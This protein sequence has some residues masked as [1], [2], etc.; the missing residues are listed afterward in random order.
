MP[1]AR[2]SDLN[3][4]KEEVA[5]LIDKATTLSQ[6]YDDSIESDVERDHYRAPGIHASEISKCKRRMVY[7][8][9]DTPK[10]KVGIT[11]K[12][13][14]RFQMGK[15]IHLMIQNDFHR[16]AVRSNGLIQ[17]D[18]EVPI[19]PKFQAIA[20]ELNLH[21]S[22][23][24][25]FTFRDHLLG[26]ATLRVGVEIKTESPDQFEDLKAPR[27]EHIEQAH[28]YMKALDLPLF[29][30]MYFNKGNQNNTSSI[31]PYLI[32]FNQTLWAKLEARCR[33]VLKM[34]ADREVPDREE[35]IHCQ[36][37]PYSAVCQPPFLSK[38]SGGA[39]KWQQ[40]RRM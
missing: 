3:G 8:I 38:K 18:S 33:L 24:G 23:D 9:L 10:N 21:S 12:W 7:N 15:L 35:G 30:F 26:P 11:K 28:I 22:C 40:P 39:A 25:V 36:F 5:D 20:A 29:Y 34:A 32:Q 6:L 37:C 31:G 14:Q 17:F 2:I 1:L 19:H 4:P 27:P 16:M 13:R